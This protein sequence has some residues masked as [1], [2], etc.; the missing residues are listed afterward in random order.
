MKSCSICGDLLIVGD[1]HSKA[2]HKRY[3]HKCKPCNVALKR[4]AQAKGRAFVREYKEAMGCEC[5]GW[6]GHFV[7]LHLAHRELGTKT[8]NKGAAYHQSWSIDRIKKEIDLCRVLCANCHGI[9][10]YEQVHGESDE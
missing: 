9:E 5:C 10:T 3:I 1:N 6:N 8:T 4:A 7:S 2:D